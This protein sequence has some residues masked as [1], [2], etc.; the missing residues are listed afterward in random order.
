MNPTDYNRE[1]VWAGHLVPSWGQERGE[2]LSRELRAESS[3]ARRR[4]TSCRNLGI[5]GRER[6]YRRDIA[7]AQSVVPA[8]RAASAGDSGAHDD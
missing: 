3:E 1:V 2:L 4:G 6:R 8:E 5:N 7:R